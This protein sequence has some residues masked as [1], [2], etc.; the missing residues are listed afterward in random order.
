MSSYLT[1]E[2]IGRKMAGGRYGGPGGQS[3]AGNIPQRV[4]EPAEI[5]WAHAQRAR[6]ARSEE[7]A[8]DEPE[9]PKVNPHLKAKGV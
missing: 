2:F 3:A 4:T 9:Q 6:R 8:P 7:P 5:D 1:G